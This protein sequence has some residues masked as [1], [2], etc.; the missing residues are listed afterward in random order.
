[1]A[2]SCQGS[3]VLSVTPHVPHAVVGLTLT[4][5][6]VSLGMTLTQQ[7]HHALHVSQTLATH[8]I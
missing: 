8:L 1:M 2:T 7:H 3:S 5:T 6:R 4:V